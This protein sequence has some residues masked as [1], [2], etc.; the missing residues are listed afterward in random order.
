MIYYKHPEDLL[1][2][3]KNLLSN[4]IIGFDIDVLINYC[5]TI[6]GLNYFKQWPGY[7]NS[8]DYTNRKIFEHCGIAI[9]QDDLTHCPMFILENKDFNILLIQIPRCTSYYITP[10]NLLGVWLYQSYK[11]S[12]NTDS[13]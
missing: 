1:V 11:A 7:F 13:Y 10:N 12:P 5:R 6:Y 3:Y 2:S 8:F 4:S 9:I